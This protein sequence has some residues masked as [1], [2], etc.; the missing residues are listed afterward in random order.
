MEDDQNNSKLKSSNGGRKKEFI[1]KT[2][3]YSNN[4][5]NNL[6]QLNRIQFKGCDAAP[7]ILGLFNSVYF[8][9]TLKT[10]F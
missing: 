9:V 2:S 10:I 6:T 8:V 3:K 5:N 1:S 4:K 7:G